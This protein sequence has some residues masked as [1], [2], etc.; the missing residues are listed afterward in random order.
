M[1]LTTNL[2]CN[3]KGDQFKRNIKISNLKA[4]TRSTD[5][6][7]DNFI[8]H[9]DDEYDYEFVCKKQKKLFKA[10]KEC[11]FYTMNRN[12]P[13][14]GVPGEIKSYLTTKKDL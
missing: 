1:L 14:Y 6:S 12:L 9:V 2:L 7:I 13:I 3:V 10:I 5:P 8:I 4:L 11:Y